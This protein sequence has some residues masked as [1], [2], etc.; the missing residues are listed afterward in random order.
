MITQLNNQGNLLEQLR[1]SVEACKGTIEGQAKTLEEIRSEARA[2]ATRVSELLDGLSVLSKEAQSLQDRLSQMGDCPRRQ[3]AVG[4][5][6][7]ATG[8]LLAAIVAARDAEVRR[9]G[10]SDEARM[11]PQQR[12]GGTPAIVGVGG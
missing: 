7:A 12:A 1:G 8:S 9:Q 11:C 6:P 5:A 3:E 2:T 4:S 10:G